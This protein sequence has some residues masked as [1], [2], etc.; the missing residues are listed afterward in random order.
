[1]VYLLGLHNLQQH[2]TIL[3]FRRDHRTRIGILFN[4]RLPQKTRL[5][6]RHPLQSTIMVGPR[7]LRRTLRSQFNRHRNRNNL[8]LRLHLPINYQRDKGPEQILTRLFDREEMAK[9]EE[10]RR[11]TK[12]SVKLSQ[13]NFLAYVQ[14][15]YQSIIRASSLNAKSRL[16]KSSGSVSIQVGLFPSALPSSAGVGGFQFA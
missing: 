7:R 11:D 12:Q 13:P 15:N 5:Y 6:Y 3:L 14:F 4:L 8:R 9:L 16:L 2:Y 1:M 10:D